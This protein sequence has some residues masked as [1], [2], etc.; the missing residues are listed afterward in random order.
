MA[1]NA[2]TLDNPT[3]ATPSGAV[4]FAEWQK[5]MRLIEAGNPDDDTSHIWTIED[6]A[7]NI[8]FADDTAT[9]TNAERK[10]WICLQHLLTDADDNAAVVRC[11]L[12]PLI[13]KGDALD[14]TVR[15]VL[16]AIQTLRSV[17]GDA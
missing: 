17:R 3:P 16:S 11:N 7:E 9:V 14:W 8:V 6:A 2:H 12:Q 1:T 15:L 5:C 13:A 10:L 4:A